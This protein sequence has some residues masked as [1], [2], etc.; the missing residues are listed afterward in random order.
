MKQE[1]EFE[2]E[3]EVD[4]VPVSPL[5]SR[6]RSNRYGSV[7]GL[8]DEE[9]ASPEE[10]ERQITMEEWWPILRL[11]VRHRKCA[12]QPHIDEY[13]GVDWG[14]FATVDFER[15]AGQFDKARYK[16]DKLKEKLGNVILMMETISGRLP[17]AKFAV[18]R[19]VRKGIIDL[20][21]I[22]SLDMYELARLDLR[23]R[24]LRNEIRQLR[25]AS[26]NRRQGQLAEVE[27]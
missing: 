22:E 11:P 1:N 12:I 9:L 7:P 27:A 18:L 5:L 20:G 19:Y 13:F 6:Q 26:W 21:H 3:F 2:D 4:G 17:E 23:A 16:A 10:L 24:R 15:Y 14:A 25:K 8:D